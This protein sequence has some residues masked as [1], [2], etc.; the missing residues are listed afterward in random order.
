MENFEISEALKAKL[1]RAHS[2]EEIAMICAEEGLEVTAQELKELMAQQT[3]ELELDDLDNVAGG[4]IGIRGPSEVD[5]VRKIVKW[6][7]SKFK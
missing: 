5:A 7:I 3:G 6:I 4:R 2:L 1:E